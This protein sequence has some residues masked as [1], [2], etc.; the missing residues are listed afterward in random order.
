MDYTRDNYE[1]Y[2]HRI[3]R[4]EPTL[5]LLF[6]RVTGTAGICIQAVLLYNVVF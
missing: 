2:T 4:M 5:I 3:Q 1:V 6:I